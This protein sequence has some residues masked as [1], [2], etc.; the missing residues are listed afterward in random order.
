MCRDFAEDRV[1]QL[2]EALSTPQAEAI[3]SLPSTS[4]RE[5]PAADDVAARKA[6]RQGRGT[7]QRAGQQPGIQRSLSAKIEQARAAIQSEG[8]A[9]EL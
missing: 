8:S 9:G 1:Q 6:W 7:P 4:G 2:N 5:E 3:S